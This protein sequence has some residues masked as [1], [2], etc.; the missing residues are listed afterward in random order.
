MQHQLNILHGSNMAENAFTHPPTLD[1]VAVQRWAALTQ[2]QA[3]WL[4]EEVG[5]RMASRLDWIKI[6]PQA[7]CDWD[8]LRGGLAAHALVQQRYPGATP[9]V[10]QEHQPQA[11][12]VRSRLKRRWWWPADWRRPPTQVSMPSASSVQM[13]WA[14]MVLHRVAQPQSVLSAWHTALAVDGFLMFSCLGPDTA[15]ELRGLYRDFAWGPMGQEFTDMHDWGDMLVQSGFAEPVMDMERIVLTYTTAAAL[16][17][18]LRELGRNFH[19]QRFRGLRTRRW[20]QRLE[21]AIEERLRRP[22]GKLALTFEIV[23]GHALKPPPRFAVQAQ[24]SLSLE[25]MRESLARN[26]RPSGKNPA[27]VR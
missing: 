21:H 2:P 10:A 4:H 1:P 11:Q 20:R 18:D 6:Q 8:G 22:D 27:Q 14:N 16:L 26:R 19:P 24:S 15:L 13:L 5:Q 25:Q 7:W 17:Q 12:L 9:L 3:A 23:Y